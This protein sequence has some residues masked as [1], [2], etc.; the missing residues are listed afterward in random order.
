MLRFYNDLDDFVAVDIII[1][2]RKV[3]SQLNPNAFSGTFD[4]KPGLYV[5]TVAAHGETLLHIN[6]QLRHPNSSIVLAGRPDQVEMRI[7]PST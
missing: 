5:I 2:N 7:V 6:F 3:V 1:N 4:A